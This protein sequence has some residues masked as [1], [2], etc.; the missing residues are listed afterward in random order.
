[1]TNHPER[2][3]SAAAGGIWIRSW[4]VPQPPED[5]VELLQLSQ[6]SSCWTW[7]QFKDRVPRRAY[8][9]YGMA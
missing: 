1:V 5:G 2:I 6:G 9:G 8:N 4:L 3:I 7:P